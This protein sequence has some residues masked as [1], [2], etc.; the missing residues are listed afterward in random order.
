M[1]SQRVSQVA[2]AYLEARLG[3]RG[4]EV[5]ECGGQTGGFYGQVV[6]QLHSKVR[7]AKEFFRLG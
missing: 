7:V 6:V 2:D 5:L 4:L 3:T 1:A